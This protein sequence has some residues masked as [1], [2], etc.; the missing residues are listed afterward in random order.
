ML[1]QIPGNFNIIA[2]DDIF[3]TIIE[4]VEELN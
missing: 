4:I 2:K 1:L 3:Y